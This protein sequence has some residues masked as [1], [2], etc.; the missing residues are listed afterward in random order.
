M[1]FSI[2]AR[3]P[4]TGMNGVA[5][6]TRPM[7]IGAKCPFAKPGIGALVVQANGD[8]R[9]GPLGLKLLEMGYSAPKVLKELMESDGPDN[10]EWRQIAVVDKD[11]RTA[12][13]TGAQNEDWKGHV[14]RPNAVA[15]GNRLTSERT[16]TAMMEAFVIFLGMNEMRPQCAGAWMDSTRVR[17][18]VL[19][20][21]SAAQRGR[22]RNSPWVKPSASAGGSRRA[23]RS[24]RGCPPAR[25]APGPS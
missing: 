4:R 2:V 12:A 10:I 24:T 8:P 13:H 16:A 11:G 19:C 23:R 1:T 15:L 3:C 7:A 20:A 9:L 5:I 17:A 21:R 6:A 25:C 18:V 14:V 22:T